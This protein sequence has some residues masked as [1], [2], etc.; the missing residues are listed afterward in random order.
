MDGSC[1]R[2]A[3]GAIIGS[4]PLADRYRPEADTG[5]M[6]KRTLNVRIQRPPEAVRWRLDSLKFVI[7][8]PL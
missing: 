2:F 1:D 5:V 3:A 7:S 4:G 8:D 6:S